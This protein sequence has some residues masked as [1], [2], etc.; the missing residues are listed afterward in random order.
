MAGAAATDQVGSDTLTTEPD[1]EY[2]KNV[3][4]RNSFHPEALERGINTPI[5]LGPF[6]LSAVAE[7]CR[8]PLM[9]TTSHHIPYFN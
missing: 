9:I 7:T 2:I 1:K 5:D 3:E 8:A 6:V 4:R